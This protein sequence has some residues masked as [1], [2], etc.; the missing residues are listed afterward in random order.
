VVRIH[1]AK[2]RDGVRIAYF[3]LGSGPP[4]VFA[5]N[6]FG[7]AHFYQ[8]LHPHTRRMT[9]ALAARGWGV[10][11]YDLRGMG[12]SD[13]GAEQLTEEALGR[14]LE[15]VVEREGLR[16]FALVGL[17]G[18]AATAVRYAAEHSDRVSHLVLLNPFRT[19]AHPLERDPVGRTLSGAAD[20]AGDDFGFFTL[21]AGNLMTGF[22]NP[23]HA[24]DLATMFQ[25]STTP[26][27]LIEYQRVMRSIDLTDDL[28]RLRTPVLVIHDTGFPFGSF[29][30]REAVAALIPNAQLQVIPSDVEAE[31]AAIDAFLRGEHLPVESVGTAMLT[32]R[33]VEVLRLV[34]VGQTN[35][36]IASWLVISERTVARHLNNIY[37]KIDA[38][39]K[40]EATAFAMRHGIA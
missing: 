39:S 15:G 35:R 26:A 10:V 28:R 25:R 12:E 34:A 40:A 14:D 24:R 4:V 13:P 31:V 20:F 6:V 32:P 21:L 23:G 33:E 16:R 38:H 36:E 18:G 5:S 37:A 11:R 22:A 9:D 3:R 19:G 27:G 2:T 17:H 30:E 8:S 1:Y 29:A 7:D